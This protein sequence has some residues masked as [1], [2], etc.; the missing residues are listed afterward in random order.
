MPGYLKLLELSDKGDLGDRTRQ[1]HENAGD[2][3]ATKGPA[4]E[5]EGE[6]STAPPPSVAGPAPVET[7]SEPLLSPLSP[8]S[9]EHGG[10]GVVSDSDNLIETPVD[11][12]ALL[13]ALPPDRPTAALYLSGATAAGYPYALEWSPL[14]WPLTLEET[15]A[16]LAELRRWAEERAELVESLYN[17]PG[18][19]LVAVWAEAGG[20]TW[21][22][23]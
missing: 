3:A 9:P 2:I 10:G 23:P 15:T 22:A 19:A 18:G 17:R 6:R 14:T 16:H 11:L 13:E 21:G 4:T 8:L 20:Q 5:H 7:L 1:A 12:S